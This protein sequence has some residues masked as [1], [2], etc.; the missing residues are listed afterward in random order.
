MTDFISY[1]SSSPA[2]DLISFLAGIKRMWEKTGKRG[3]VYQ[4]LNMPGI[5]YAESIHPFEN[6]NKEPVTMN[7]YMFDHLRP[8]LLSQEYIEDYTI[9]TGQEV[10]FDFDELRLKT[11]TSQPKYSLNRWIF[12]VFPQMN[13]DL[14]KPWIKVDKGITNPYEDKVV[15]NFTQ[16]HR[17]HFI[18]YYW[19]KPFQDKI[20]FAGLQHERDIFCK[21]FDLDIPLLQVDNFLELAKI[22]AGCK[23]FL[24]NASF[25]FQLAEATK[26]K[27]IIELFPVAPNVI[28]CG[29]DAYDFFHQDACQH[30]FNELINEK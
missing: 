7:R 15:I 27:R 26:N 22:I 11:Y 4:R 6:E 12:L 19:L 29:E 24:G 3:I 10:D 16:R 5:S 18:K 28:P 13:C 8:L 20:V 25:C 2:G 9:Y 1:L 17:Q 23:F 14:S 30:Y 21:E